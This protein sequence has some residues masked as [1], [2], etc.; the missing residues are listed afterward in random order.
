MILFSVLSQLVHSAYSGKG[1]M[2]YANVM[3]HPVL[4]GLPAHLA[5]KASEDHRSSEAW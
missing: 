2:L 3:N 1:G 4:F 5:T